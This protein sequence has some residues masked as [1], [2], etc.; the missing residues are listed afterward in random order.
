[1]QPGFARVELAR[2]TAAAF[3]GVG[4]V[5]EGYVVVA[6]VSEPVNFARVFEQTQ[7]NAMYRGVA[8]AFVE[9]ASSSVEMREVVFIRLAAPEGHVGDFKVGPKVTR[10]VP[11]GLD[12][13]LRSALAV[14]E[15]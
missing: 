10:A 9:E 14:G 13:M 5:I 2:C 3:R 8:P 11:V 12:V 7:R 6:D 4:T 15:P 1:L